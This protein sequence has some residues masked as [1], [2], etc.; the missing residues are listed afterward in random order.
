MD[1]CL[2]MCFQNDWLYPRLFAIS[3][4]MTGDSDVI[5]LRKSS[6]PLGS[7]MVRRR[8]S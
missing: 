8:L 5:G 3:S 6:R 2:P 4:R 1:L 7:F